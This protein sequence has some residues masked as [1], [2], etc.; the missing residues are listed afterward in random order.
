[1]TKKERMPTFRK[2]SREEKRAELIAQAFT[3]MQY[4]LDSLYGQVRAL[5]RELE[6]Q[7][8]ET[9]RR[10]FMA[11]DDIAAMLRQTN[12]VIKTALADLDAQRAERVK[13]IKEDQ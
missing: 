1:M 8:V 12:G 6:L 11:P 2:K 7:K 3:S 9:N 4:E 13:G 5:T 10:R